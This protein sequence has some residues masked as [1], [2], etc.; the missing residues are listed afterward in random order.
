MATIHLEIAMQKS[1][2][3]ETPESSR[4]WTVEAFRISTVHERFGPRSWGDSCKDSH[5]LC[6]QLA[7]AVAGHVVD[8][9]RYCPLCRKCCDCNANGPMDCERSVIPFDG[10]AV[11]GGGGGCKA[12]L[13]T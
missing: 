12:A 10:G 5:G 1:T 9:C 13:Q 2:R 11:S 6:H 7:C 3:K 8:F 4:A